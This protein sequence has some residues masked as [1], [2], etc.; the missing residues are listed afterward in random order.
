MFNFFFGL[1]GGVVHALGS[2]TCNVI[3]TRRKKNIGKFI[4]KNIVYTEEGKDKK[5]RRAF[6]QNKMEVYT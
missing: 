6:E 2:G 3:H 5:K 1:G 4:W